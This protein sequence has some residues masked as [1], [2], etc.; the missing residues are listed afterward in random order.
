MDM[1][2][3]AITRYHQKGDKVEEIKCEEIK[4]DEIKFEQNK[5]D[6]SEIEQFNVKEPVFKKKRPSS[7]QPLKPMDGV[8]YINIPVGPDKVVAPLESEMTV[9]DYCATLPINYHKDRVTDVLLKH[10]NNFD[11]D[12]SYEKNVILLTGASGSGKTFCVKRV[13]K[14][15][16]YRLL[17]IEDSVHFKLDKDTKLE[18][19]DLGKQIKDLLYAKSNTNK[20]VCVS[21]IEGFD[22]MPSKSRSL[23]C[24]LVKD[25]V[26]M[27]QP[28]AK[29]RKKAK[30]KKEET[31]IPYHNFIVF[32]SCIKY[33]SEIYNIKGISENIHVSDIA[34]N[35][36]MALA[37]KCFLHLTGKKI[38]PHIYRL[39]S[40]NSTESISAVLNKVRLCA[41]EDS[42]NPGTKSLMQM[43]KSCMDLF[44]CCKK[45]MIFGSEESLQMPF[46]EY[47]LTWE[48]GGEKVTNTLYNSFPN[49]VNITLPFPKEK[50]TDPE[51][52]YGGMM[53]A[54]QIADTF[55]FDDAT[56]YSSKAISNIALKYAFK[57]I[58]SNVTSR[59]SSDINVKD[60]VMYTPQRL[61]F[62]KCYL[63][64]VDQEKLQTVI[65]INNILADKEKEN[66]NYKPDVTYDTKEYIGNYFVRTE[67]EDGTVTFK[68]YNLNTQLKD[69]QDCLKILSHWPTNSE[70]KE[71]GKRETIKRKRC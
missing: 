64:R 54:S 50:P 5:V 39:L 17:N 31:K 14:E 57:H 67:H 62:S 19:P 11:A 34:H 12:P 36:K 13:C 28:A 66:C 15:A 61:C 38:P 41:L 2:F 7:D 59:R 40:E 63:S 26:Q 1:D 42:V 8:P 56:S 58:M 32:T 71:T 27:K 30:G 24:K 48:L 44:Q 43:D 53:M 70:E 49:F 29:K 60:Y 65:K 55:S 46:D 47:D 51:I 37:E 10:L 6:K 21:L 69:R 4:V 68:F 3:D 52:Y 20:R 22:E 45:L 33:G 25:C 9:T 23:V 35:Q 18:V 16:G